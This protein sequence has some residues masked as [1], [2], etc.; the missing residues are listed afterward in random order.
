MSITVK[1]DQMT[2]NWNFETCI[3]CKNFSTGKTAEGRYWRCK[4]NSKPAFDKRN[5]NMIWAIDRLIARGKLD[6]KTQ[7]EIIIDYVG[8]KVRKKA[9]EV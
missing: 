4:L 3:T 8:K 2:D 6:E 5:F 9:K 7:Y 1:C